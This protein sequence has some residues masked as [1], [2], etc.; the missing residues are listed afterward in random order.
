MY[1]V[2]SIKKLHF[3]YKAHISPLISFGTSSLKEIFL[4]SLASKI[5]AEWIISLQ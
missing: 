5:Q 4:T 1:C 2:V 3:D